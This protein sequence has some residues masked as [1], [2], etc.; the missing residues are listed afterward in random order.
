[1]PPGYGVQLASRGHQGSLATGDQSSPRGLS[2]EED[3]YSPNKT[4][5]QIESYGT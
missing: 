5:M 1:M 2:V 4:R 3:N